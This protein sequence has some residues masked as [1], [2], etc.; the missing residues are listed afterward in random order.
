MYLMSKLFLVTAIGTA[1]VSAQAGAQPPAPGGGMQQDMTRQQAQ[2][3]AD[4]AFARLD[5]NHDGT[6][7]RQ[8]ADQAI[9]EAGG[10]G[11]IIER[12]FGTAQSLSLTQ[13]EAASLARFDQADANHDGVVT[14]P[15]R[16]QAR[17]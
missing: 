1:I 17:A 3:F 10:H 8:E 9:A 14:A 5:L 12:T 16:Q 11:H 15:E 6:V 4:S 7:T 13:F 2:Q